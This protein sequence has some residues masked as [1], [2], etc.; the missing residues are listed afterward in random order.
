MNEN[1]FAND[2]HNFDLIVMVVITYYHIRQKYVAKLHT[3]SIGEIS[4]TQKLRNKKLMIICNSTQ[5]SSLDKLFTLPADGSLL[6]I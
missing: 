4:K 6:L 1:H 5:K 3:S 2:N